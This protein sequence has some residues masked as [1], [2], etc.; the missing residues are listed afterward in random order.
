MSANSLVVRDLD[1]LFRLVLLNPWVRSTQSGGSIPLFFW[2][3]AATLP[4]MDDKL[5]VATEG[6]LKA[7]L[8]KLF[9]TLRSKRASKETRV[10]GILEFHFTN[11]TAVR[12]FLE[13]IGMVEE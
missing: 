1:H 8:E 12:S 11:E 2:A 7:S 3:R 4:F 6:L 9:R 10:R 5:M 13:D